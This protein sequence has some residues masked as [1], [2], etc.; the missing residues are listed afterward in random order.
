[1]QAIIMKPVPAPEAGLVPLLRA[2]SLKKKKNL[3]KT[4]QIFPAAGW[5]YARI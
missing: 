3:E 5:L 2:E 4:D 1:M